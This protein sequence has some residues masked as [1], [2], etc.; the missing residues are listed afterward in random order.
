MGEIHPCVVSEG[1]HK[2]GGAWK[3]KA[4]V[5][6]GRKVLRSAE[7]IRTATPCAGAGPPPEDT[8]RDT[9]ASVRKW[10]GATA[11]YSLWTGTQAERQS[12]CCD[13]MQGAR[14]W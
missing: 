8:A 5:K 10:K 3:E 14:G 7:A 1:S 6:P 4:R 12:H 9:A 11:G 13:A 2:Q